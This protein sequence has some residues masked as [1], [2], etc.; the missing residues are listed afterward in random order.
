M[1]SDNSFKYEI[2]TNKK[3]RISVIFRYQWL[4]VIFS[5]NINGPESLFN[6]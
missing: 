6:Y 3:D 4:K 5:Q 1:I 2:V